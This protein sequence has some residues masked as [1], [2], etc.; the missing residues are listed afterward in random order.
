M[1][2]MR[3]PP[4]Q[5]VASKTE[6]WF[7]LMPALA[8]PRWK[9]CRKVRVLV[10]AHSDYAHAGSGL[11]FDG[12]ERFCIGGRESRFTIEGRRNVAAAIIWK[13]I[14]RR[15]RSVPVARKLTLPSAPIMA[16]AA[17]AWPVCKDY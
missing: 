10:Y 5:G 13:P 15:L 16:A 9:K 2:C 12:S 7:V 3:Q 17:P 11:V 1:C 4:Q 8:K 14:L 6:G